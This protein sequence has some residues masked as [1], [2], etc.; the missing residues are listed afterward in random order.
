MNKNNYIYN[1]SNFK[2]TNEGMKTWLSTFLILAN[3]GLV[4]LHI[5]SA[6]SNIKKEFIQEQPADKIDAAKFLDYL[7]NKNIP[8]EE[9]WENFIKDDVT[10]KSEFKDVSK[11][12]NK[13]N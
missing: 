2:E 5:K 4:P 8:I 9:A 13:E 3:L 11:Y 12:L 1:Y 10:I 6:N 7:N